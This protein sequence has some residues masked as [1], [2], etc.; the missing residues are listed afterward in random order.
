MSKKEREKKERKWTKVPIQK[1]RKTDKSLFYQGGMLSPR[2]KCRIRYSPSIITPHN[3]F[4]FLSLHSH[5]H[6]T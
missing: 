1:K 4:S 5:A 2:S 6:M 3:P